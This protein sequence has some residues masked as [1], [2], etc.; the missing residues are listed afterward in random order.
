MADRLQESYG[1][2][3]Q[4]VEERTRDLRQSILELK[5]LEEI[6]RAVT[7]SLD[8]KSVLATIVTRAVELT[9]ADSS[10]HLQ[11]RTPRAA[12][13]SSRRRTGS[14]R[15]PRSHPCPSDQARRE[16]LRGSPTRKASRSRIPNLASAPNYPL[17]DITLA[18]GFH[19]VLVVPLLGQDRSSGSLVLQRRAT[20]IF[21]RA[22]S[23]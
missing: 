1:A 7:S 14:T 18:A 10:A 2:L 20:E 21:R 8:P 4:K 16:R 15:P 11:L 5:A 12:C 17:K 9:Q 19:S 3:E 22:R 13:S 6:G 23:A